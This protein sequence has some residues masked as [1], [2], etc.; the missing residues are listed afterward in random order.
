M[1]IYSKKFPGCKDSSAKTEAASRGCG[2]DQNRQNT[3]LTP[4]CGLTPTRRI[5]S[6]SNS[7]NHCT[8][9][10]HLSEEKHSNSL[11]Y[12]ITVCMWT[13]TIEDEKYYINSQDSDKFFTEDKFL[14]PLWSL[15]KKNVLCKTIILPCFDQVFTISWD[16]SDYSTAFFSPPGFSLILQNNILVAHVKLPDSSNTTNKKSVGPV[17]P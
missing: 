1:T 7:Q 15:Q 16:S 3:A 13:T 8:N 11:K 5:A 9:L 12:C 17:L 4:P 6:K 14:L 10:P 2:A